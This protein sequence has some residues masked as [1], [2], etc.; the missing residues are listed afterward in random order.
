F[1][2]VQSD[3]AKRFE[4]RNTRITRKGSQGMQSRS[5]GFSVCSVYSVVM[6]SG[7]I[8]ERSLPE[9]GLTRREGR[10]R[11]RILF[12][13]VIVGWVQPTGASTGSRRWVA[14]TLRGSALNRL[15]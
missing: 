13:G 4:P 12:A 2:T 15:A 3:S 1:L 5:P 6:D 14:P 11:V 10:S 8:R 7:P 9:A